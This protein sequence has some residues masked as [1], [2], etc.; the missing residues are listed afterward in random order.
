MRSLDVVSSLRALDPHAGF[1]LAPVR[2][3]DSAMPPKSHARIRKL[4]ADHRLALDLAVKI[5]ETLKRGL[6]PDVVAVTVE[7]TFEQ[8]LEEH[9]DIE[10]SS[11]AVAFAGDIEPEHAARM[12]SEHQ[13]IRRLFSEVRAGSVEALTHLADA[14]EAH[15]RFEETDVYP[16]ILAR[17]ASP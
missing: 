13:A 15:V 5:R 9:F 12:V 7:L 10:E 1:A 14:L 11:L 17:L 3:Y 8:R 6:D 16:A 2:V 4:S